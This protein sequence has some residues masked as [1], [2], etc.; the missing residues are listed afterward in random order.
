MYK[1]LQAEALMM[2]MSPKDLVAK[3]IMDNLSPRAL[4]FMGAKPQEPKASP[5]LEKKSRKK[6]RAFGPRG[7]QKPKIENVPGLAEK[8]RALAAED[9]GPTEI[10]EMVGYPKSTVANFLKRDAKRRQN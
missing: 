6:N 9:R 3:W 10:G 7:P 1:A 2:D 5:N 4:E 8:I